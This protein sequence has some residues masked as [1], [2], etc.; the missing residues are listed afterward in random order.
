MIPNQ[1]NLLWDVGFVSMIPLTII[2]FRFRS[3]N[4]FTAILMLIPFIFL[5]MEAF[6]YR[7]VSLLFVVFIAYETVALFFGIFYNSIVNFFYKKFPQHPEIVKRWS[8]GVFILVC[9]F[10]II[11]PLH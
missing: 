4:Y 10:L 8:W 11:A 5:F 1:I 6:Y 7:S 3:K 2:F 9:I